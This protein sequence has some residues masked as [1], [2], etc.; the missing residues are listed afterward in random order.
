MALDPSGSSA[1]SPTTAIEASS[2]EEGTVRDNQRVCP[3]LGLGG[4]AA[5]N[6]S[7]VGEQSFDGTEPQP[8]DTLGDREPKE[9]SQE[10]H[11]NPGGNPEDHALHLRWERNGWEEAAERRGRDRPKGSASEASD[12]AW[13][14]EAVVQGL[15]QAPLPRMAYSGWHG[16][17]LAEEWRGR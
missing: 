6:P 1:A 12:D 2:S 11:V 15:F 17:R 5:M 10:D 3:Y 9:E 14:E 16:W 8:S 13:G 4:L 7:L